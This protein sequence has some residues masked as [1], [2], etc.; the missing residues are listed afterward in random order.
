MNSFDPQN[1]VQIKELEKYL[2]EKLKTQMNNI[3]IPEEF[4]QGLTNRIKRV[5]HIPPRRQMWKKIA[6]VIA[7]TVVI[8]FS[9]GSYISPTFAT[10]IKSIFLSSSDPGLQQATK[11]GVT[12]SVLYKA[13]DHGIT[14][15]V[16]EILADP[17]RVS[18]GYH[19]IKKN[20]EFILP[21]QIHNDSNEIYLT[22]VEGKRIDT[23]ESWSG[24]K[25]ESDPFS[26]NAGIYTYKLPE[27][28][29]KQMI[30]H[31]EIQKIGERRTEDGTEVITPGVEGHWKLK[32]PVTIKGAENSKKITMDSVYRTKEGIE[33]RPQEM[34]ITPSLTRF[35]VSTDSSK[36]LHP[37][38]VDPSMYIDHPNTVNLEYTIT[39]DKGKKLGI[40]G[41]DGHNGGEETIGPDGLSVEFPPFPLSDWYLFHLTGI[42]YRDQSNL[43]IPVSKSKLPITLNY[44][45]NTIK[46]VDMKV[47]EDQSV[48]LIIEGIRHKDIRQFDWVVKDSE[49]EVCTITG[50]GPNNIGTP[51]HGMQR[52]K[53]EITIDAIDLDNSKPITLQLLSIH[54]FHPVD[55][56]TT[57]KMK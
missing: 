40:Y 1:N 47:N 42:I 3:V 18:F 44:Q 50:Y 13:S 35:Y 15:H 32:I 54:R 12:T 34:V 10:W 41:L 24:G 22:D 48:N 4:N 36:R 53:E 2:K 45:E 27:D 29:P 56:K 46:I 30:L 43:S 57:I 39:D 37:L 55:W 26:S 28:A 52:F 17:S 33:I 38:S 31:I 16:S 5:S 11:N 20:G 9:L 14:M 19:I 51:S 25:D 8:G 23:I 6:L 21:D 7:A 49:G